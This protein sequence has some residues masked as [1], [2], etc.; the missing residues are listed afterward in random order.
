MMIF[1]VYS[2]QTMHAD[3]RGT[4]LAL[5]Q[6]VPDKTVR[7]SMVFALSSGVC[8]LFKVHIQASHY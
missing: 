6:A 2:L 7:F 8:G 3:S 4:D 1:S 5:W